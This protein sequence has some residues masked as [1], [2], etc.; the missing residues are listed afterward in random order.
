VATYR[1]G[2]ALADA[3]H[4]GRSHEL[5]DEVAG[6]LQIYPVITRACDAALITDDLSERLTRRF[7][8]R[9]VAATAR[10]Q[11]APATSAGPI[12]R[13]RG[14]KP[15]ERRSRGIAAEL[16][17][18]GYAITVRTGMDATLAEDEV[19]RLTEVEH[20]RWR[21]KRIAKGW[22]QGPRK[23]G[24][25]GGFGTWSPGPSSETPAVRRCPMPYAASAAR[26][27]TKGSPSV[28]TEA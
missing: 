10:L 25:D 14:A 22:R 12:C 27:P 21:A 5:L 8:E 19:E 23:T 3:F 24:G 1:R 9:Y 6:W 15:C 17:A 13:S 11:P 18:I 4:S 26:S 20:E 16:Q 2:T 7:H 28:Q